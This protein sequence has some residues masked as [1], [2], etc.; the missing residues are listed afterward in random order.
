MVR[1]LV[2]VVSILLAEAAL[3]QS[4]PRK[5]SVAGDSLSQAA[6]ADGTIPSDQPWNS[7]AYGT[8]SY[9]FS[10]LQRTRTF[11]N[12]YFWAEPVARDGAKMTRD[13]P[14][15]AA[16]ICSQ[17]W[18]PNRVFVALGQNDACSAPRADPSLAADAFMPS[19]TDFVAAL[20][21]GLSQ[22][23]SCLPS[24]SVVQV[25]SVVRVD[26]LYEAG[27]AKDWLYCPAVWQALG[28]C[29][30]VTGE[31]DPQRRATIGQ[32]ITDWNA[33]LAAEVAR[34]DSTNGRGLRFVTDWVGPVDDTSAGT[35]RFGPN[36]LNALDCFHPSNGGQRR[37]AC[38]EAVTSLDPIR[39]AASVAECFQR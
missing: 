30:I 36:D 3:A 20:Q 26:F 38:A 5:M 29:R 24:G 14:T 25:V 21:N 32:R 6:L 8:N 10:I 39:N 19:V 28:T 7:W 11:V 34:F 16:R 37:L 35:Y 18:R 27:V 1:A 17:W 2:A 13:F 15:Q 4:T 12:P 33:A 31:P 23:A 9:V 22:L